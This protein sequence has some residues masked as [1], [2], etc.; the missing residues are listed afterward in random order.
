MI[1][2]QDADIKIEPANLAY[3]DEPY[4]LQDGVN[5]GDP[6]DYIHFTPN[7]ISTL[8]DADNI[9]AYGPSGKLYFFIPIILNS[10]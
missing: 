3:G 8:K 10:Y 5:C 2:I 1:K 9:N 4:T 7:Y 6:G